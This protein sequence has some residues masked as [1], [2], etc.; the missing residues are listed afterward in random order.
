MIKKHYHTVSA[1]ILVLLQLNKRL[2]MRK[3]YKEQW[4]CSGFEP[5]FYVYSVFDL[6]CLCITLS[7]QRFWLISLFAQFS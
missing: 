2:A 7:F 6:S 4:P 1:G 5:D 3:K